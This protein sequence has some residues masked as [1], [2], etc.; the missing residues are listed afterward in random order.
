[1]SKYLS[2][3]NEVNKR[4]ILQTQNIWIELILQTKDR[5]WVHI[6]LIES[7]QFALTLFLT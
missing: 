1:M 3:G 4:N 5:N 2:I 6:Q 7:H